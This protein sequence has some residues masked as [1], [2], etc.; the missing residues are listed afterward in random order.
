MP[1]FAKFDTKTL[2]VTR[3]WAGGL[4][5]IIVLAACSNDI[6][7]PTSDSVPIDNS[8]IV[9]QSVEPEIV[10]ELGINVLPGGDATW[11]GTAEIESDFNSVTLRD[12]RADTYAVATHLLNV[13]EL[14]DTVRLVARVQLL[15]TAE[16]SLIRFGYTDAAG[17]AV[18]NDVGFKHDTMGVGRIR[19]EV[20]FVS[21]LD[22]GW[23]DVKMTFPFPTEAT[24]PFIEIY[25][26]ASVSGFSESE[27]GMAALRL[28]KLRLQ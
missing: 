26:A 20:E 12:E 7:E 15:G 6:T 27:E 13:D 16:H 25:P 14:G 18:K 17:T 19:G 10:A 8:V 9:A 28:E 24:S 3:N 4:C 22:Q 21:E 23:L 2:R 11:S 5:A 1:T